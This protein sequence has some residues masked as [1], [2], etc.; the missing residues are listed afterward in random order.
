M[1]SPSPCGCSPFISQSHNVQGN[2]REHLVRQTH[3]TGVP[4]GS[5]ILLVVTVVVLFT[6]NGFV[7]LRNVVLAHFHEAL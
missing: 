4:V 6:D 1:A 2:R 3:L 7:L 5:S